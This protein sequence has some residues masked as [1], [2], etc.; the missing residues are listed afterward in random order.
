MIEKGSRS[1]SRNISHSSFNE[2]IRQLTYKANWNNK[3]LIK[4]DKYYPS[5]QICSHCNHKNKKVKDLN[6]R[7]YEC[8]KCS[9]VNDRDINASINILDKG[10]EIF[11]K[12]RKEQL[13]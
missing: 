3:M 6:V 2:I 4:I 12:E 5:S 10:I 8:E 1:L 7:K 9:Y 11:L 13:I